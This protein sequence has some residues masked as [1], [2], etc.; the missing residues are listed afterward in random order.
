MILATFHTLIYFHISHICKDCV[1]S[2]KKNTNSYN[3]E[4]EQL[5]TIL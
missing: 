2:K 4:T 5:L 1:D 3:Q